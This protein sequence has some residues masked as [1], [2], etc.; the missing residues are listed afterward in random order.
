MYTALE[1][2]YRQECF[3]AGIHLIK[4]L[5]MEYDDFTGNIDRIVAQV[6]AKTLDDVQ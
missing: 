3:L 6:A 1:K 2:W 4:R 5:N